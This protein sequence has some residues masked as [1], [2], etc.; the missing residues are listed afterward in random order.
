MPQVMTKEEARLF[1]SRWQ[2][3]NERIAEEIRGTPMVE[4]LRQLA[5]MFQA[6]Q[7]LGWTERMRAGE[8]EIQQRW[9]RLRERMHE[10]SQTS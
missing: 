2:L 9:Q 4:K 7:A 1:R 10:R 8:E 6:G 5:I 3:A